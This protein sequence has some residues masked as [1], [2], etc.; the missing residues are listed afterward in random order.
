MTIRSMEIFQT[1]VKYM[2]MSKAAHELH[3][4]QPTISQSIQEIER[5]YEILL[6][7]R[8]GK[9][10]H[11]TTDGLRLLDYTKQIL[12]LT[13]A[14]HKE[15]QGLSFSP[16]FSIGATIT[17]GQNLLAPIVHRFE[18]KMPDIAVSVLV[19]NTAIIEEN[20]LTGKLDFAF[21]EGKT[22]HKDILVTPLIEDKLILVCNKK[23]PLSVKKNVCVQDILKYSFL[24]REDGSGTKE[25]FQ[26]ELEKHK[27]TIHVKWTAHS[28]DSILSALSE[29]LGISILSERIIDSYI[30]QE[31]LHKVN[32]LDMTLARNFS[33]VYH[34]NKHLTESMKLLIDQ[35]P[36]DSNH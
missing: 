6:F 11:I 16:S 18:E 35:F 33:L 36:C 22:K 2:N 14:M 13:N 3:I 9:K 15:M 24:L 1:V 31:N 26:N 12:T 10:L 7:N 25:L 32:I 17:I 4:A 21:I 8:I 19:D 30:Q 5:E 34:K 23:H 20:I 28:F 27:A 29:N